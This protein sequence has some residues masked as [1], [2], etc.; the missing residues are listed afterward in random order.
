MNNYLTVGFDGAVWG[1]LVRPSIDW[2]WQQLKP[3]EDPES[4]YFLVSFGMG[5]KNNVGPDLGGY[6][7]SVHFIDDPADYA[8]PKRFVNTHKQIIIWPGLTAPP[9][10][11]SRGRETLH[12]GHFWEA[13]PFTIPERK[14]DPV[15]DVLVAGIKKIDRLGRLK[16]LC[17]NNQ[18][19]SLGY[20]WDEHFSVTR[21]SHRRDFDGDMLKAAEYCSKQCAVELIYHS[22][23]VKSFMSVRLPNCLKR[24]AIPAVDLFHDPERLLLITEKF[25]EN[26]YV[27]SSEDLRKAANFA[28]K[29]ITLADVQTEYNS[30]VARA[31]KDMQDIR[32]KLK[33]I[34]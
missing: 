31:E 7:R 27:D 18:V 20:N 15:Y 32:Q 9:E 24:G 25:R 34:Y 13:V 14:W 5:P 17:E 26:L 19:Y 8:N 4:F 6:K 10:K 28:R 2:V 30:Q 11:R 23:W 16:H 33:E 1:G 3:W 22:P 12:G 21:H 29:E